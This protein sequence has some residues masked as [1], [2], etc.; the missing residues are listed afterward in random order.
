I[1]LHNLTL[2]STRIGGSG[3]I[4]ADGIVARG[5]GMSH[6]VHFHNNWPGWTQGI[7]ATES[8]FSN[9]LEAAI[10]A[11]IM[12]N[13]TMDRIGRDF[14]RDP[15]CAINCTVT[16][17]GQEGSHSDFVQWYVPNFNQA[18]NFIIYNCASY[19]AYQNTPSFFRGSTL[20]Q[21]FNNVAFV[22]CHMD[23]AP[24]GVSRGQWWTPTNHMLLW[25]VNHVNVGFALET[26]HLRNVS[27]RGC[28]WHELYLGP[29]GPSHGGHFQH[30]RST[31][32][33]NDRACIGGTDA[34]VGNPQFANVMA[35]DF[36]PAEGSPLVNR[37][38]QTRVPADTASSERSMPASVGAFEWDS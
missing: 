23:R 20:E 28:I 1:R 19:K 29:N 34:T 11:T 37:L 13:L 15:R 31:V 9:M 5:N 17:H 6:S 25:H 18:E 2:V 21:G 10:R 32:T 27:I 35:N 7:F 36:R 33:S 14:L 26:R 30:S 16:N 24:G 22:N 38:T 8:H 12:R 4:W 3:S